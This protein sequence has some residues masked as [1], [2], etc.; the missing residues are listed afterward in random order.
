M[1]TYIHT[2]IQTYIHAYIQTHTYIH[3]YY[4]QKSKLLVISRRKRKEMKEISVY[5]NKP[6]EEVQK[7]KYLRAIFDSKLNFKK[8]AIYVFKCTYQGSAQN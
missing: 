5:M 8:Y 3:T 2:Y 6:L 7:N 4:E 1:H